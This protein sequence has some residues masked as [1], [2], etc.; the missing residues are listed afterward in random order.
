MKSKFTYFWN[1]PWSLSI[2]AGILLGLSWPPV[3]L[4]ILQFVAFIFLFRLAELSDGWRDLFIKS[5]VS[6]V[7]WNIITTYWLMMATISGGVAAILA[8]SFLMVLP[9]LAIRK[10]MQL[11]LHLLWTALLAGSVWVSYEFLHHQWD[12][13]WPWLSLGNGWSNATMI[14][15]YISYTGFLG[16]SFWVIAVSTAAW[17]MISIPNRNHFVWTTTLFLLFPLLSLISW[18]T[19]QEE[20]S[21][22]LNV[23]IVQPNLDSYLDY[24]GLESTDKVIQLLM[25]VSDSIRTDDTDLIIWPENA[26]ET[27]IP[28]QNRFNEQIRDSLVRWNTQLI[29]GAGFIDN[30]ENVPPPPVVRGRFGNRSFNVYNAA[31]H[32][33]RPGLMNI[34][35]KN[36]LVP[37]VERFPFVETFN[38]LDRLDW[39]SWGEVAG[40]GIGLDAN[41]FQIGDYKTPALICYDSVFP[42]WAGEFVRNGAGF[43]TIITNDGWWGKTS[44][45]VQHFAYARLRAIEFRQWVAR[46]A[47]NGISGIIAPDGSVKV[48]TDYWVRTGFTHTIYPT[49]K[50]TFFARHGMAFNG[51][52]LLGAAITLLLLYIKR[53]R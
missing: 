26:I 3:D 43:L 16:I 9:L 40:Y 21:G 12:L 14:I 8:N 11:R 5:Y 10:L 38:R 27:A 30:Y 18:A 6:F 49:E 48:E 53:E 50:L 31:F 52:M 22:E 4:P 15:Q 42:Q 17:K 41:N 20:P 28:V 35:K 39:I 47:N 25:E 37:V 33:D 44:G 7:I 19:W 34:Y 2:T 1:Q 24:G 29:T 45:H 13:A 36:K 46:S 32:Y 51:L 23:A